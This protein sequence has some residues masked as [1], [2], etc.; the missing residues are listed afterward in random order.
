MPRG[1]NNLEEDENLSEAVRNYKCLYD[2]SHPE[3]K[4]KPVKQK[5]WSEIE[6]Y[7]GM[8]EDTA[9]KAWD[10]LKKRYS[11]IRN[12]YKKAVVS[13]KGRDDVAKEENDLREYV[14]LTWLDPFIKSRKTKT[15]APSYNCDYM[16]VNVNDDYEE[17]P[18]ETPETQEF[19]Q[20]CGGDQQLEQQL[21]DSNESVE[22]PHITYRC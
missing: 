6:K 20:I 22:Y 3:H 8:E 2:K 11:R 10:N 12:T 18:E 5:C 1:K 16:Q 9:E 13:G 15:N 19:D 7:L 4:N 17:P 14:F 21:F